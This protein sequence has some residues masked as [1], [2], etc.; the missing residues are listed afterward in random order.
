MVVVEWC[1]FDHILEIVGQVRQPEHVAL[2]D[3]FAM[4]LLPLVLDFFS[5]LALAL[6]DLQHMAVVVGI[7]MILGE[8]LD[9]LLDEQEVYP[10]LGCLSHVHVH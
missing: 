9:R 7:S 3:Q 2:L 6:V 4:S 8:V 5:L 1:I 10:H